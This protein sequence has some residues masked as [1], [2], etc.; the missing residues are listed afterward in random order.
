MAARE[1]RTFALIVQYFR[2]AFSRSSH[3]KANPAPVPRRN[4]GIS[5]HPVP[6]KGSALSRIRDKTLN[7]PGSM[8]RNVHNTYPHLLSVSLLPVINKQ[9]LPCSEQS[10]LS[11][12]SEALRI[13]LEL[14]RGYCSLYG[15]SETAPGSKPCRCRGSLGSGTAVYFLPADQ[16]RKTNSLS[17]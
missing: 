5:A 6:E 14:R 13:C 7:L 16:S 11:G 4:Q 8:L 17:E 10:L 9:S 12:R 1:L 15:M 3:R 2:S